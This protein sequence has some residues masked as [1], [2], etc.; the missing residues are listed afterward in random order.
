[1]NKLILRYGLLGGLIVG[2]IILSFSVFYYFNK[3]NYHVGMLLGYTAMLLAFTM[4][5]VAI[6]NYRDKQNGG[7]ISFGQALKMG[8]LITLIT[9][10]I[11]VLVWL[12][13]YYAMFPDF[14]EKYTSNIIAQAKAGGASAA[15]LAKTNAEMQEYITMY[16]NPIMVI[17]FTYAEILPIGLIVSLIAAL[18]LMKKE[19]R[20]TAG[21][22]A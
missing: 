6:K 17:L 13:C 5:F 20:Q 12:F 21:I 10:S 11:Y 16:K 18:I 19:K 4:I 15:E 1:M 22:S 7:Y 3:Q 14:M 9:S 2:G 8:L